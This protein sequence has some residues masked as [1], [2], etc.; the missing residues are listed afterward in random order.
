MGYALEVVICESFTF[1][2]E[3]HCFP[4]ELYKKHTV[5]RC[6]AIDCPDA[7]GMNS[8]TRLKRR[9]GKCSNTIQGIMST[10]ETYF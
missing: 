9:L 10:N 6:C 2:V 7:L 8:G 3:G 5:Q 4:Q 1:T